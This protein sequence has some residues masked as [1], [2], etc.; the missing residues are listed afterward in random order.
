MRE[1]HVGAG[2]IGADF[3]EQAKCIAKQFHGGA[4]PLVDLVIGT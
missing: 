4:W 3:A 2:T 1:R